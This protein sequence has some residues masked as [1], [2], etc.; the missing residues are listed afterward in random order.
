MHRKAFT[1]IELLVVIAI[2]AI[3]AAILFPVFAQAKAAAKKTQSLSNL[4]QIGLAWLMYNGDYDE[5]LMRVSVGDFAGGKVFYWWGSYDGTTLNVQEGLIYPYTK[6]KGIQSDPSQP[7]T[8]RTAIG[9]TGYGYNYAYFSPSD[10]LPPTWSEVPRPVNYG[11]VGSVADTVAFATAARMSFTIPHVVEGNPYLEPP[12]NEYPSFQ[13]RHSG[14]GNILWADGHA[15]SRKPALRVG[16]F[17]YGGA[18]NGDE[19]VK[20]VLGEIDQDG[21]LTTDEL[22][23]LN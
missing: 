19:F 11:S 21:D 3:L 14:Q 13:G 10:Y 5:T 8:F 12:S 15:K 7:D 18:Y 2:I 22:F 1:L 20:P 6:S 17:G 23:D 4:K 16:T 9:L